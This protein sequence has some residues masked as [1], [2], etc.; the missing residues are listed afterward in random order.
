MKKKI[1]YTFIYTFTVVIFNLNALIAREIVLL[2]D[3][4]NNRHSAY[5]KN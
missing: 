3:I 5:F 4:Q 2:F 1:I